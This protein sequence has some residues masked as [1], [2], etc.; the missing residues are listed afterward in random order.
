MGISDEW[1]DKKYNEVFDQEIRGLTR[2][3]HSESGCRIED[4]EAILRNLYIKDGADQ[5]GRGSL[6]DTVMYATIAA[7]EHFIAQWKTETPGN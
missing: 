3:R 7:Y 5:E 6:Q 4:L 1:Q 2:R